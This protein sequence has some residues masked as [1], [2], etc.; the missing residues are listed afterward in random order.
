MEWIVHITDHVS[1]TGAKYAVEEESFTVGRDPGQDIRVENPSVS[2]LH[3][4]VEDRAPLA[5]IEDPGSVNGTYVRIN[6]IL[7]RCDERTEVEL[8]ADLMLGN[9]VSC[10]IARKGAVA[11]KDDPLAGD[12]SKSNTASMMLSIN[13]LAKRQAIMVL[14]LCNSTLLSDEDEQAAFHSK[15]R[16]DEFARKVLFEHE[17]GFYKNTGD[18]FVAAFE[19]AEQSL[20]ASLDLMG[21][22]AERNRTTENVPIH[23]RIALHYGTTYVI[24][25]K[26]KDIHGKDVNTA[27]RIEGVD[28]D[29]F[30]T[31]EHSPPAQD[32]IL[33]SDAFYDLL[34]PSRKKEAVF[35]GS[36]LLK[37]VRK[38]VGIYQIRA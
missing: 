3:I 29:S 21:L 24:D 11:H 25:P 18:G 9:E 22:L 26:T 5:L 2:R 32:R 10:Q 4:R 17:A 8:P 15:R 33:C 27:F 7:L 23:I 35:C 13:R 16:M 37:G 38:P 14:D 34:D 1:G 36:A 6:G 20:A 28:G 12:Q 30:E 31:Q 19:D